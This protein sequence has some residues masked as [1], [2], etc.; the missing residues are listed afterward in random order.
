M[1]PSSFEDIVNSFKG[2][3]QEMLN[4]EFAQDN[5]IFEIAAF[6]IVFSEGEVSPQRYRRSS[7]KY[8]I[9]NYCISLG[10]GKDIFKMNFVDM[11]AKLKC[12]VK[13]RFLQYIQYTSQFHAGNLLYKYF[14]SCI[15]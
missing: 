1:K 12:E 2:Q 9:I 13:L 15:L 11:S 7:E 8:P 4:A 10:E 14:I 5:I 3:F 6:D